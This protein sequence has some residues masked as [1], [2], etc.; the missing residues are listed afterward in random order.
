MTVDIKPTVVEVKRVA[1]D[2]VAFRIACDVVDVI[3]VVGDAAVVP[4]F[5]AV[6]T[7]KILP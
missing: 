7:A 5:D 4:V 1:V 6:R 3:V 2:G